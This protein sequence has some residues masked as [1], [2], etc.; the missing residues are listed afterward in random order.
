V[1][2]R[3]MSYTACQMLMTRKFKRMVCQGLIGALLFAQWSVA[4]YACPALSMLSQQLQQGAV[5]AAADGRA[6]PTGDMAAKTTR[7]AGARM[8]DCD[9]MARELGNSSPSLCF[10]HG[11]YGQQ[12]DQVQVPALPPIA[13]VSLYI[14]RPMVPEVSPPMSATA[15]VVGAPAA[16]CPPHTILHCCFRV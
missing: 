12:S 16:A 9:Q 8:T 15:V 5:V 2:G 6:M 7:S 11:H 13:L 1:Y 14:I 4:A 3:A 10:E